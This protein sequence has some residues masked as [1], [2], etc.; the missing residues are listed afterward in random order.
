M[1]S[2]EIL[3]ILHSQ[4]NPK[5]VK[6]MARF[7]I[8]VKKTL[9]IS[10]PFLRQLAKKIGKD[11]TL[12]N[13]LWESEIHEARILAAFIDVPKNVTEKQMD[14]WVNDFDSWDI[15]D[16]V[17]GNLFDQTP[18]AYKKAKECSIY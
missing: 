3:V 13:E 18:F 10:I 15:C 17:C 1:T 8:N 5:N 12:A 4:A 9:G 2:K 14:A 11:H 16:Q 7:G 6:G